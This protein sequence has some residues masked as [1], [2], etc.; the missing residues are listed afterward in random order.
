M[1]KLFM[2]ILFVLFI[3]TGCSSNSN[4][5]TLKGDIQNNIISATTTISGKIVEMKKHQG[6]VVKKGD[7]IAII[8]NTNQKYVVEQMQAV[9]NMKKAKLE[10][11]QLGTRPQQIEQAEA[12]VR[13]AKAQL[14]LLTSGNRNEQI[15]QAKNEVSIAARCCKFCTINI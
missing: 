12:Q 3:A 14:D 11:L 13:A 7:I 1:K 6:E 9:V 10:E 15:E 5:L 8:D 4:I 2:C